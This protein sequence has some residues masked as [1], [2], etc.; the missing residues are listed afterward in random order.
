MNATLR[1]RGVLGASLK[2]WLAS[3]SHEAVEHVSCP[4]CREEMALHIPDMI[5]PERVL[6]T[7]DRCGGWYLVSL[8][9]YG[10]SDTLLVHF[11][12][13]ALLHKAAETAGL[14]SPHS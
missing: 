8:A 3:E 11:P 12:A 1:Q 9:G 10:C 6:A 13:A 7:C 4:K 5:R 14:E 2:V